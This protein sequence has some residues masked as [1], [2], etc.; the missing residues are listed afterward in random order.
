[1]D[2]NC[3]LCLC[4]LGDG[5]PVHKIECGHLFHTE[6]IVTALRRGATRNCAL[7]R[8]PPPPLPTRT[9][10][11]LP[12]HPTAVPESSSTATTA[13]VSSE[14]MRRLRRDAASKRRTDPDVSAKWQDLL[15]VHS[16]WK[17]A[18][19]EA[20]RKRESLL[21]E[22]KRKSQE[23]S[24][25]MLG[26]LAVSAAEAREAYEDALK[27]S[28]EESL[29][30]TALYPVHYASIAKRE[31]TKPRRRHNHRPMRSTRRSGRGGVRGGAAPSEAV[32]MAE[33]EADR[34]WYRKA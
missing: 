17:T 23:A 30:R 11:L 9:E 4:P 20:Y 18:T 5:R 12:S 26:P 33:V 31:W 25:A 21:E 14:D 6:C 15:R 24:L 7:C 8:A 16:Q 29:P 28:V 10:Q 34:D 2:D 1:M 27:A 32:I 3:S 22:A 13:S 19:V